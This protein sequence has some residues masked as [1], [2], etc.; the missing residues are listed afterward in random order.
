[1]NTTKKPSKDRAIPFVNKH[2]HT[3]RLSGSMT[4]RE[5]FKMGFVRVSLEKPGSPLLEGEWRDATPPQ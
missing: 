4:L 3:M 5:L 1:M 2:G